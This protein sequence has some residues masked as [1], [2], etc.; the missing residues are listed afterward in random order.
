M[1]STM[2]FFHDLISV[3]LNVPAMCNSILVL[4]QLVIVAAL[5][6]G[7]PSLAVA[8][9]D[10]PVQMQPMPAVLKV[11]QK[12]PLPLCVTTKYRG[13]LSESKP[14]HG[15]LEVTLVNQYIL[16]NRTE[17]SRSHRKCHASSKAVTLAYP[18]NWESPGWVIGGRSSPADR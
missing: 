1:V 10:A 6:F 3:C 16:T 13:P 5:S 15:C 7:S 2:R 4:I 8:I 12:D 18:G 17:S 9:P 11:P 14:C